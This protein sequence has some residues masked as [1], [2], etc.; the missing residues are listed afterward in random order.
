LWIIPIHTF[1]VII[2]GTECPV[3]ENLKVQQQTF[4][5]YTIRNSTTIV[6]ATTP[7]GLVSFVT[8]AYGGN[9]SDRQITRAVSLSNLVIP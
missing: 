9:T 7:G 6:V 2:D 3:K 5:T 4:S 8:E 1:C